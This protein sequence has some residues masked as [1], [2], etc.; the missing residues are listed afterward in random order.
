MTEHTSTISCFTEH[1]A[2]LNHCE[3]WPIISSSYDYTTFHGFGWFCWLGFFVWLV[4][5]VVDFLLGFFSFVFGFF[6]LSKM[7]EF[8]P[9]YWVLYIYK[10]LYWKNKQNEKAQH[11]HYKK[12]HP[13]NCATAIHLS[14]ISQH[15]SRVEI[16]VHKAVVLF[17]SIIVLNFKFTSEYCTA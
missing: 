5:G 4:G 16:Y 7:W 14:H 1:L 6:F 2:V 12:F 10:L 3:S 13:R 17:L 15:H 9:K 11:L 8:C